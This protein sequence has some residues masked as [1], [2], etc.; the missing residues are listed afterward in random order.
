MVSVEVVHQFKA[1]LSIHLLSLVQQDGYPVHL[2]V[3]FWTLIYFTHDSGW[4]V[5]IFLGSVWFH[6]CIEDIVRFVEGIVEDF[7][8][9]TVTFGD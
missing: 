8:G 9:L 7:F 4:K 2:G 6:F 3:A 5:W 1:V